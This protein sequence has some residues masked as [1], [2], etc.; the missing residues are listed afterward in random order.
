MPDSK[1]YKSVGIEIPSYEKLLV[2]ADH[3]DRPIGKQLS[4]IINE[5]Y[6]EVIAQQQIVATPI[7]AKVGIGGVY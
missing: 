7:S 2:I 4:R 3:E 6:E 5:K 1:K